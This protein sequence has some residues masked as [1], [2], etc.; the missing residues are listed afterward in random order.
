MNDC[1]IAR[2]TG[3][4]WQQALVGANDRGVASIR[5]HFTNH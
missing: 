5:Y 3:M 1:A 2:S 4:P